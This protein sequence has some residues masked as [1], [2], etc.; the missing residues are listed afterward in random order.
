M[1]CRQML[2]E[3]LSD[4]KYKTICEEY[5]QFDMVFFLLTFLRRM[6]D[7]AQ[8]HSSFEKF[9]ELVLG[10]DWEKYPTEF[11][12][13]F[14]CTVEQFSNVDCDTFLYENNQYVKARDTVYEEYCSGLIGFKYILKYAAA[15]LGYKITKI[16]KRVK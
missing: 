10:F 13:I 7:I 5:I 8:R 14:F 4:T 11:K 12:S 6:P 16:M 1:L 15:W 3:T 9:R 2:M